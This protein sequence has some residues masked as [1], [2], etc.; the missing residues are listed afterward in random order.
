MAIL[1]LQSS[2]SALTA[3]NTAMDVTANNL[4]NINTAGFKA[5]RVNFQDLLYVEKAQPGTV[6][7]NGDERPT[8]LYV[9]LGVK[10]SGTQVSFAQGGP[11]VTDRPLDVMISGD[12][13]FEVAV[14]DS[15]GT[16][17]RAYTRAGNFALNSEGEI[18]LANDQGRRLQPVIQVPPD[19]TNITIGADGKVFVQV[20]S[21]PPQELNTIT[22]ATFINPAGLKQVGEN[23]FVETEA[24]GAPIIGEPGTENRGSLS[25]GMLEAS[26]V[27]PTK[28]L[29]ELIRIQ[30]AFDMNS[31]VIRAADET[32]RNVSQLRRG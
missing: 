14:E 16:G 28:E 19:A 20:G 11:Q 13:F 25:Q 4:A 5:S 6:N 27:D 26:N 23:L 3:L 29:I 12:G 7:A 31:Q 9:G 24:S 17:G 10:V 22:L 1:S 15:L 18:V 8:G 21:D 2:S 30:R 32:L